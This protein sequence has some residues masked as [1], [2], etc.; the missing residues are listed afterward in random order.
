MRIVIAGAGRIGRALVQDMVAA[1]HD[2]AVIETDRARA[3]ALVSASDVLVI[4]GDACDVPYLEQ[5]GTADADVFV[6]TTHDDDANLVAS[7][8]AMI[9]FDVPRAIARV[10]AP[11]NVDIFTTLGIEP[12]SSTQLISRLIEQELAVGELVHL[13]P[14]KDGRLTLVELR[15]PDDHRAPPPRTVTELGLPADA[16]L[17]AVLRGDETLVPR[18]DT[19]VLPGDDVIAIA[20][21]AAEAALRR[22]L[23]GGR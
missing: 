7:Q 9:A 19:R 4:H 15:L 12:V 21:P 22:A 1:G 10:N 8:L 23:L 13:A 2:V 5:A 14:I 18:G 17:V 11:R 16:I 20:A 6:A 3:E